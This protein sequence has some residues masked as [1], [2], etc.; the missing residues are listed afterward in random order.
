MGI[1]ASPIVLISSLFVSRSSTRLAHKP[2]SFFL[3]LSIVITYMQR[4][5]MRRLLHRSIA[6]LP[7]LSCVVLK[8]SLSGACPIHVAG[9]FYLD[10][11]AI[12][13]MGSPR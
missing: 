5:Q 2:R 9:D 13:V 7:L 4:L 12:V 11:V 6:E 1:F 10:F 8:R 3:K